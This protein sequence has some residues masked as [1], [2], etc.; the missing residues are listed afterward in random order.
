MTRKALSRRAAD[1]PQRG[2]GGGRGRGWKLW[3]LLTLV[4]LIAGGGAWAW[5]K[6][7]RA[8]EVSAVSA[9]A[10]SGGSAA[11]TVLN[12]SGYVTARRQATVSSKVTGKVTEILVEEGMEVREGQI[13]ARLDDSTVRRQLALSEAQARPRPRRCSRRPRSGSRRRGSISSEC[14]TCSRKGSPPSPSWTPPMPRS[15]RSPPGWRRSG[16][17]SRSPS[18]RSPLPPGHG[19]HRDPRAVHRRGDLARTPSRA[20]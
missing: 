1:R 6:M 20:R 7:P 2:G 18:A 13:L 19:R 4:V 3:L 12:A 10:V 11:G 5:L 17:T 9:R 14:A 16:R 15:T 8:V